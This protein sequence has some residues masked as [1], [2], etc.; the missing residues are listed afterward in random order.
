MKVEK[1]FYHKD[2]DNLE[3]LKLS[4]ASERVDAD[5]IP[6]LEKFFS[7]P[8]TPTESCYGHVETGKNPYLGYVNDEAENLKDL[9]IQKSFKEKINELSA[10]INRRIGV[11]IVDVL[12]E[13]INHG[14]G[15]KDCTLRFDIK[16]DKVF[17]E[18][19]KKLL[20]I[21]WE[22]FSTYIKNLK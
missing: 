6:I 14:A 8:I 9:S 5:I 20:D 4:I 15:P 22:E 16:D 1:N 11:E 12:L 19:G 18:M 21:I 2:R 7:L 3:M 13:E 17:K 10:V